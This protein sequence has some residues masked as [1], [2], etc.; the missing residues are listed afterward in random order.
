MSELFASYGPTAR[1]PTVWLYSENDRYWGPAIP[2]AWFK[3]FVDRG[4]SGEFVQLPPYKADGHSIFTGDPKSWQPALEALLTSC[5]AL[6]NT[7]SGSQPAVPTPLS[8]TPEAFTQV[9]TAWAAR[10]NVGK[11]VIVVRRNGRV[12]HQASLGGADPARPVLLASLSKA[13]TGACVATLIREGRLGFQ[14]TLAAALAKF[15]KAHGRP[16]D[17]RIERITIAQLLTHRAGF[18]SASDGEDPATRSVLKAYLESHSS[19]EA[20][21]P[22]YLAMLFKERLLRDPGQKFA[23]SNAGYLMLGAVIEEA[24]GRSYEDYCRE[25]VLKPAGVTGALDPTWAVLWSTGGWHMPGADYLAAFERL[26]PS[27]ATYGAPVRA[28]M[29]D[30]NGKTFGTAKPPSWY[31]LGV[32]LRD[33]GQG[34]VMSHTGSWRAR[35]TPPDTQGPRN[36]ETSTLAVV[37]ADGTSWF[38]HSTPLV[39]DGARD[40]LDRDL[41]RAYRSVRW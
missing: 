10:H 8:D 33:R 3:A 40:E 23:Y 1:I 38:V 39:L 22:A 21:K 4:G 27:R 6:A 12:V 17:P 2:R 32:R 24:T 26:A 37:V 19:R 9:L 30:P 31:G 36:T 15:F 29:L 20:P 35:T 11:A 13:I 41:L 14:T 28:W 5:C 34:L 18:S 7:G 16:A 25:A